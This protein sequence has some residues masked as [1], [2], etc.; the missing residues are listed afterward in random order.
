MTFDPRTIVLINFG[1]YAKDSE[2]R[3]LP[4]S[5]LHSLA[6]MPLLEGFKGFSYVDG[7]LS[8]P[9]KT[10][11]IV[12]ESTDLANTQAIA[13]SLGRKLGVHVKCEGRDNTCRDE[14][15]AWVL[16]YGVEHNFDEKI[17]SGGPEWINQTYPLLSLF[18]CDPCREEQ[19]EIYRKRGDQRMQVMDIGFRLPPHFQ[20]FH[21]DKL[22][23]NVNT[24]ELY[25]KLRK[26]MIHLIDNPAGDE[27]DVGRIPDRVR[28]IKR[29]AA[30][31]VTAR[32]LHVPEE[33][34]PR[35]NEDYITRDLRWS[36]S[37]TGR[38]R[39]RFLPLF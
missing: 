7:Y 5:R 19:A 28:M 17:R 26:L 31:R 38:N 11:P 23:W 35:H 32:L 15:T 2:G 30:N 25:A 4:S 18:C 14:A 10:A 27:I 34:I 9:E 16:P 8:N 13:V 22:R 1:A 29:Y 37:D 12:I 24:E 36:M 33:E 3:Y 39:Q 6:Q 21:P 20:K